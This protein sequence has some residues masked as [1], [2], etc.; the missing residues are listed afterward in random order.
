MGDDLRVRLDRKSHRF[1]GTAACLRT[2][3]R[4]DVDMLAPEAVRAMVGITV[5]LYHRTAVLTY[6]IFFCADKM[7]HW[8]VYSLF[9]GCAQ[10]KPHK[11]WFFAEWRNLSDS[12]LEGL[13]GAELWHANCRDLNGLTSAWVAA[14]AGAAHLC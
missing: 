11:V 13:C 1:H 9:F 12:V 3:A 7:F 14:G 2:V 8:Y 6:K 5:A 10:E 4:I